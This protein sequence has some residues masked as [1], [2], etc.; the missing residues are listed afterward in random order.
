[1]DDQTKKLEIVFTGVRE[2][3]ALVPDAYINLF[4]STEARNLVR[5]YLVDG[6]AVS[7]Q[8]YIAACKAERAKLPDAESTESEEVESI[9]SQESVGA[10]CKRRKTF[11]AISEVKWNDKTLPVPDALKPSRWN[12]QVALLA[13]QIENSDK[14]HE[15][16]DAKILRIANR[17]K[18]LEQERPS[19]RRKQRKNNNE[20]AILTDFS[21]FLSQWHGIIDT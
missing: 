1:M 19:E 7:A 20:I 2:T 15:I 10:A 11:D 9:V 4:N 12:Q 13:N 8:Q 17:S 6:A 16:L 14:P 18:A 3:M 21:D 5:A